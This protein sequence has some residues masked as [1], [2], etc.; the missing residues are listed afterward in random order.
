MNHG[1]KRPNSGAKPKYG[2]PTKSVT[3]RVPESKI[4]DVKKLVSDYL[5]TLIEGL[6]PY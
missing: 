3:F 2:E 5:K 1:G 6:N 4:K